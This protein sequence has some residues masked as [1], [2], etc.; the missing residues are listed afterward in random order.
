ML[1][2][3]QCDKFIE[4]G[5][6]RPPITFGQG[7]NTILG[8]NCGANSIGKSTVLMLVDFAFGGIDYIRKS[9]DIHTNIGRHVINFTFEFEDEL[10]Y[11]SRATEYYA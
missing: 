2:M 11:F 4:N 1:K 6:I 9:V 5:I 10:Y 3:I 7:L 8:T